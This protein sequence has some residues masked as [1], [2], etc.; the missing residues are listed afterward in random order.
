[1]I[2]KSEVLPMP[3][4][5]LSYEQL[6]AENIDLREENK[7][8]R[9]KLGLDVVEAHAEEPPI[10]PLNI[11]VPEADLFQNAMVTKTSASDEKINLFMSLFRGRNDAY[12]SDRPEYR[13]V[14]Q[15]QPFELWFCRRKHNAI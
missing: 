12:R 2:A 14:W 15:H 4:P 8:L 13:L 9:Q 5:K 10:V 6:L 3:E 1:M 11:N 7:L